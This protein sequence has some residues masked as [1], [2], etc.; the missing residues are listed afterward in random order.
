MYLLKF[1][2]SDIINRYLMKFIAINAVTIL[3]DNLFYFLKQR[4]KKD[5]T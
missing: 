1:V 3:Q 4:D 2:F 5:N